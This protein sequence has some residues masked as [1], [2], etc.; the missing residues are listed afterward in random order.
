MPE[1]EHLLN[2]IAQYIFLSRGRWRCCIGLAE[3]LS[4]VF[5]IYYFSPAG[6]P[7]FP[8]L[9]TAKKRKTKVFRYTS[10]IFLMVIFCFAVEIFTWLEKVYLN[11]A[12]VEVGCVFVSF[13]SWRAINM[14]DLGYLTANN[15]T[16]IA[17][18]LLYTY[19]CMGSIS[20]HSQPLYL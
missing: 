16:L 11:A 4:D 2:I 9:S 20:C 8:L 19:V 13:T 1:R 12:F 18:V 10:F 3:F 7:S 17:F 6:C 14:D 15:V 5:Y